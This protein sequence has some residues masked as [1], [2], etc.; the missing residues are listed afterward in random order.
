MHARR[1]KLSKAGKWYPVTRLAGH[2]ITR[3]DMP[4]LARHFST[5]GLFLPA[6]YQGLDTLQGMIWATDLYKNSVMPHELRL[7]LASC[8]EFMEVE[9]PVRAHDALSD[10]DACIRLARAMGERL[11]W[12]KP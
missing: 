8:C 2:N 10:V 4:I 12:G 1:K 6:E 7:N 3:F 5:C 9:G 11:G